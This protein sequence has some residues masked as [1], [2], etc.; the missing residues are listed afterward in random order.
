MRCF[1]IILF[2][3]FSVSVFG[4]TKDLKGLKNKRNKYQKEIIKAN[5][6][7]KNKAI[8]R[9]NYLRQVQLLN[10][11]IMNQKNIIKSYKY[12][13]DSLN[14]IVSSNMEL[15]NKISGELTILKNEYANLIR[16]A[17]VSSRTVNNDFIFLLS[18]K[19]LSESYRRF[20]WL[21]EFSAYRKKQGIVLKRNK[22]ILDSLL[23]SNKLL[24]K[25]KQSSYDSLLV[26]NGQLESAL[27][28]KNLAIS[29]LLKEERW[30]KKEIKKKKVLQKKIEKSIQ[31]ALSN[32]KISSSGSSSFLSLK[33]KL[34]W[35]VTNGVITSA[36]GEHNH[37]VL[38][39]VKVKNNGV[40]IATTKSSD[41]KVVS[42]GVVS[43]VIA[44]PG[45]N[46]AVIVRHGKYLTVYANLADVYVKNNQKVESGEIIGKLF[47]L[48]SNST[49]HFEIWKGNIK[50][51]PKLWLLN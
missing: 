22:F 20:T 36:F 35:P 28:S 15:Y 4:Q 3:F 25:Q 1:F 30:L 37:S 14:N 11:R 21:K 32:I 8:S 41:V 29:R 27:K 5:N 9:S 23:E 47:S 49:L 13:L 2:V 40:D 48:D 45:Y 24:A 6:M 50:E 7:L 44:I 16:H 33:G 39:G 12:E 51:N 46:K 43:R 19:S 17:F 42:K 10:F 18:S 38:K 31:L 34:L 26:Y